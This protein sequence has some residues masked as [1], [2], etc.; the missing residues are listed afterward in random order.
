MSRTTLLR[1]AALLIC[2]VLLWPAGRADAQELYSKVA[3]IEMKAGD[4]MRIETP[5]AGG[6]GDPQER[7]LEHI[8]ADLHNGKISRTAA[9]RDYGADRVRTAL[10]TAGSTVA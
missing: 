4:A 5:G 1:S 2:C 8:A 6:F 10:T 3:R 7:S 9:E